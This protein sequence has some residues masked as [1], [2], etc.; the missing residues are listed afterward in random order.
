[1]YFIAPHREHRITHYFAEE[2]LCGGG[3]T[4]K[5]FMLL[6]GTYSNCSRMQ[7]THLVLR[8]CVKC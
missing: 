4:S 1:M 2:R 3:R 7:A 5:D 8:L 6:T